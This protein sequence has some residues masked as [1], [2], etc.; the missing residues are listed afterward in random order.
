M[1]HFQGRAAKEAKMN[2]TALVL[3][4][5]FAIGILSASQNNPTGSSSTEGGRWL[6]W[7]EETRFEYVQG[8]VTAYQRGFYEACAV[9]ASS[10]SRP[11]DRSIDECRRKVPRYSRDLSDYLKLITQYYRTYP[12]DLNVA[13]S[14]LLEAFSDS[15]HL[16]IEQTHEYYASSAKKIPRQ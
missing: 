10:H 11:D 6:Q 2:R 15:Q 13:L 3:L 5:V 16:T 12:D 14:E 8:Y 9:A 1:Q 7:G 4:L